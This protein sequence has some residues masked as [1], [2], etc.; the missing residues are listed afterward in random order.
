[1]LLL[2]WVLW[3][4]LTNP[5]TPESVGIRTHG[6]P[7]ATL[8]VA[9]SFDPN[10]WLMILIILGSVDRAYSDNKESDSRGFF[11]CVFVFAFLFFCV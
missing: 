4:I 9:L 8:C 5:R 10:D 6:W 11:V 1:M 7:V 2:V 3:F